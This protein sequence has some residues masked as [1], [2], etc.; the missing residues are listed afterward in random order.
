M[1]GFGERGEGA[2]NAAARKN[3]I[4][5][6]NMLDCETVGQVE[7]KG[8]CLRLDRRGFISFY[9]PFHALSADRLNESTTM[10]KVKAQYEVEHILL[11]LKALRLAHDVERVEDL[12]AKLL[13]CR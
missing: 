10:A 9:N 12:K 8:V 2:A 11:R 5:G 13:G 7:E 1:C 3:K 6:S 4:V